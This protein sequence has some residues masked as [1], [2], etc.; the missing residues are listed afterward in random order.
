MAVFSEISNSILSNVDRGAA[1]L[2]TPRRIEDDK[3]FKSQLD[4][5]KVD[6]QPQDEKL[7]VDKPILKK[8]SSAK[9]APDQNVDARPIK[10]DNEDK[11][12]P[13]SSDG[14]KKFGTASSVSLDSQPVVEEPKEVRLTKEFNFD[15][16]SQIS[17]EQKSILQFMLFMKDQ[18]DVEPEKLIQALSSLSDK[19]LLSTPE[20]SMESFFKN[21]G[22][23]ED[24]IQPAKEQYLALLV[25]LNKIETQKAPQ[26]VESP[27]E[28]EVLDPKRQRVLDVNRKLDQMNA[29]F[30][31]NPP[32][33]K[34]STEILKPEFGLGDNKIVETIDTPDT[35]TTTDQFFI[36]NRKPVDLK[37]Q[38]SEYVQ[39]MVQQMKPVGESDVAVPKVSAPQV[40]AEQVVA[41]ESLP[42]SDSGMAKENLSQL[43]KKTENIQMQLGNLEKS[44]KSMDKDTDTPQHDLHSNSQPSDVIFTPDKQVA[45][46]NTFSTEL[47]ASTDRSAKSDNPNI[48]QIINQANVMIRRGGGEMK[49][50]LNPEGLGNVKLKV[51]VED[52]K[53]GIQMIA[54]TADA[55]RL[56]ESSIGDLKANLS[57]HKMTV[58][59][60]KV[61]VSDKFSD[62]LNQQSDLNREEARQ[63]LGQFREQNQFRN[64]WFN[65]S[66][67]IKAYRQ[68]GGKDVT[69]QP[70]E[71]IPTMSRNDKGR[72]HL[73]A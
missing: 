31:M 1:K 44:M 51:K 47:N 46:T 52:G 30:F 41:A 9:G 62:S 73:V 3:E 39:K 11:I 26:A 8:S 58:D 68:Y 54:D 24:E 33:K 12:V 15:K 61:D 49:M 43:S 28:V 13:Y 70:V 48:Q 42:I 23:D 21:L 17:D 71:P 22:L 19:E 7:I 53:V 38:P 14:P 36:D 69:K 20:E 59:A 66:P 67:G 63:F 5:R 32:V 2:D 56:L 72:I 35:P 10:D 65:D 45:Q 27:I 34:E 57:Q 16:K 18:F 4:K 60:F 64:A 25:Q 50:Q 6:D 29:S 37:S 40:S 55:K